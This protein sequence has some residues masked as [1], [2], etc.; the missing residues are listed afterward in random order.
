MENQEK[1]RRIQGLAQEIVETLLEESFFN[2][3][4]H[5]RHSVEHLANT[6]AA[7][8]KIQLEEDKNMEDTLR[9]T[10]SKMK[11]AKNAVDQEKKTK[12]FKNPV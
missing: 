10:V 8:T 2:D 12:Q 5:L 7:L 4:P 9:Y 6:V 1:L 11:I 3:Q